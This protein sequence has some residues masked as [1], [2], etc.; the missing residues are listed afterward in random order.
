MPG[1]KLELIKSE[2]DFNTTGRAN[3]DMNYLR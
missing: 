3:I 1:A 2:R